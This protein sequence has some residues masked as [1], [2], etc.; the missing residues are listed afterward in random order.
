M[1]DGGFSELIEP[2]RHG[3]LRTHTFE[4]RSG[5][6]LVRRSEYGGVDPGE[7]RETRFPGYR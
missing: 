3:Y 2:E 4:P 1:V 6:T 7:R 5:E